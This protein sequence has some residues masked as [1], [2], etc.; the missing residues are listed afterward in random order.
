LHET[1]FGK[2]RKFAD[3]IFRPVVAN[4]R[5]ED[6]AMAVTGKSLGNSVAYALRGAGDADGAAIHIY[7]RNEV[8]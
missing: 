2:G 1:H 8:S 6:H 4:V 3:G 7:T 5:I